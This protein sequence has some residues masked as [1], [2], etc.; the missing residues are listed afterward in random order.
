MHKDAQYDKSDFASDFRQFK[1]QN[2]KKFLKTLKNRQQNQTS[3][4]KTA[5]SQYNNKEDKKFKAAIRIL[6]KDIIK[7]FNE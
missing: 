1:N 6:D 4:N 3:A 5:L 7:T 2:Y